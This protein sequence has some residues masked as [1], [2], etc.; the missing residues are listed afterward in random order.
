MK[1]T[2]LCIHCLGSGYCRYGGE[3]AELLAYRNG[4]PIYK[5]WCGVCTDGKAVTDPNP[6]CQYCAYP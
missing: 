5:V 1:G 2:T 6:K 3:L 4:R